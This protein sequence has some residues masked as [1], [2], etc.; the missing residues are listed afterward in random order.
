[1]KKIRVYICLFSGCICLLAGCGKTKLRETGAEEPLASASV[2][3]EADAGE[4][5][6]DSKAESV[7]SGSEDAAGT[8][9]GEYGDFV[10]P[11]AMRSAG[12]AGSRSPEEGK[13]EL[14]E[15]NAAYRETVKKAETD[16]KAQEA[17]A[18]EARRKAEEEE[19]KRK[20]EQEAAEAEEKRKAEEDARRAAEEE[21]EKNEE[22]EIQDMIESQDEADGTNRREEDPI[23][24]VFAA[25]IPNLTVSDAV[26]A[27]LQDLQNAAFF[28]T[29]QLFQR[30]ADGDSAGIAAMMEDGT[31]V[32][33]E[34]K[35]ADV[36]NKMEDAA[37]RQHLCVQLAAESEGV[38]YFT[39]YG[40]DDENGEVSG[41]A[42][43]I[44]DFGGGY[45]YTAAPLENGIC[46]NCAGHCQVNGI[47]CPECGGSGFL[48][49]QEIEYE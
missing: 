36:K 25:A 29:Q 45:V 28:W 13:K 30:I 18:E 35:I 17:A 9:A 26:P 22:H 49:V 37:R 2:Q 15:R 19:Q 39:V 23:Q 24:A 7:L 42:F 10:I 11:K 40:F 46:R 16:R 27:E 3:T 48:L 6:E 8:T 1:M 44:A 4:K 47:T 41:G 38:L 32:P 21:S 5:K 31:E 43:C 14:K 12:S 33:D 34:A 20:A